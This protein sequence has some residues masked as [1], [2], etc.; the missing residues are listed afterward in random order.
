M[1][2]KRLKE[3]TLFSLKKRKLKRDGSFVVFN[4]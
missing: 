3:L 1:N 2:E 4:Y